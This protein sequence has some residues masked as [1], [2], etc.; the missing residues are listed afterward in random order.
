MKTLNVTLSKTILI[1]LMLLLT[2]CVDKKKQDDAENHHD[3]EMHEGD[4]PHD[5]EDHHDDGE[6][7]EGENPDMS[8]LSVNKSETASAVIDNYLAIK[9]ALVNDAA[10][11]AQKA[12]K[13][14]ATS[15]TNFDMSQINASQQSELKE[16]L[17]TMHEQAEHI[18]KRDIAQQRA[19]FAKIHSE[20]MN[21]L[22]IT[23]SDRAL[24]EQ[25]CPMFADNTGG[26]WLSESK[27]IKN[28]LFGSQMLK[29][30]AVQQVIMIN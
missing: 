12:G 20:M 8:N 11:A 24:Y 3:Q 9:D 15:I 1:G 26:A 23:G 27:D 4:M 16:I 14:L 7:M 21:M 13:S 30:G 10:D 28:P 17:S 18:S 6:M 29:C 2:A 25:Y 22:A 19:H 5:G